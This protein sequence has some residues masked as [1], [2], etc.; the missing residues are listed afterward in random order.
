M[1]RPISDYPNTPMRRYDTARMHL[2]IGE[3]LSLEVWSNEKGISIH[4]DEEKAPPTQLGGI[5]G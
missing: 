3:K 5:T 1:K 4:L 2:V